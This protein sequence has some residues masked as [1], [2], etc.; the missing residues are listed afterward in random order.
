MY[1]NNVALSMLQDQLNREGVSVGRKHIGTLMKR[2]GVE[3][4][5]RKTGTIY[6]G[7]LVSYLLIP[8]QFFHCTNNPTYLFLNNEIILFFRG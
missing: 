8:D 5:Y 2:M 7:F 3:G 1:R 6:V 4:L